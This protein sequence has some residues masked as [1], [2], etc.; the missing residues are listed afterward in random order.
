MTEDNRQEM[1]RWLQGRWLPAR[2][3]RSVIQL[4]AVLL[5]FMSILASFA[6]SVIA[7]GVFPD[8][9]TPRRLAVLTAIPGV[10]ITIWR[11]FPLRQWAVFQNRRYVLYREIYMELLNG[12]ISLED[13]VRRNNAAGREIAKA[14]ESL[15]LGS[16]VD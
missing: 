14:A 8:W 4:I 10:L 6:T 13:A 3:S 15:S 9:A 11:S 12:L 7:A 5:V 1:L 16:F 2:R